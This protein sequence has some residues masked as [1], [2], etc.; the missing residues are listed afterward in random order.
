MDMVRKQ[1]LVK[2]LGGDRPHVM[3]DGWLCIGRLTGVSTTVVWERPLRDDDGNVLRDTEGRPHGWEAFIEVHDRAGRKVADAASQCARDEKNWKGRDD[4][5]LRSMAQTRATGKALRAALGFIAVMAGFESTPAEEMPNV[6][7]AARARPKKISDAQRKRL[8]A[9]ATEHN[10]P[11]EKVKEIVLLTGGVE[12]TKD[13]TVERYDLVIEA[14]ELQ[15]Q[16][17]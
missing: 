13:L 15:D 10:V 17:F 8:F 16:P 1:G 2:N 4:Y 12:S 5:A 14:I 6:E 7:P 9:I 3:V 11:D